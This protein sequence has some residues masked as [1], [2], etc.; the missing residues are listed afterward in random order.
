MLVCYS[1][2]I[3][4]IT[5]YFNTLIQLSLKLCTLN[6]NIIETVSG[7]QTASINIDS[8]LFSSRKL[9]Y[10]HSIA[11]EHPNDITGLPQNAYGYGVLITLFTKN[12]NHPW[13]SGQIYIPHGGEVSR[14]IYVRT[15]GDT[16]NENASWRV[17]EPNRIINCY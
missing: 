9:L 1:H 4:P 5:F 10:I 16:Y 11:T 13:G 3:P 17:I 6:S 15:F 2:V 8:E 14:P 12:L 7:V